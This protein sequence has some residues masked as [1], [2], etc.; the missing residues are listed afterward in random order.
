MASF[1]VKV[2]YS[3]IATLSV[4]VA[5]FTSCVILSPQ[6][7]T[8]EIYTM[9]CGHRITGALL[10]FSILDLHPG[11]KEATTLQV[12]IDRR[13]AQVSAADEVHCSDCNQKFP[14]HT[15]TIIKDPPEFILFNILQS[16]HKGRASF[17]TMVSRVFYVSISFLCVRVAWSMIDICFV[18]MNLGRC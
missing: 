5:H 7:Y 9:S 1:I 16:T 18:R 10:P 15:Q 8:S 17:L 3:I 12:L 2:V 11:Q 4:T 6:C 13:F 14:A